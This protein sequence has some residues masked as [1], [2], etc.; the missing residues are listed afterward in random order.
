MLK[1]ENRDSKTTGKNDG[2]GTNED[3]A[4]ACTDAGSDCKGYSHGQTGWCILYGKGMCTVP[5]DMDSNGYTKPGWTGYCQDH[6]DHEITIRK[7]N[8]AYICVVKNKDFGKV[9]TVDTT[10]KPADVEVSSTDRQGIIVVLFS[11]WLTCIFQ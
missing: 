10:A 7:P 6:D 4:Q 11:L 3:C 8:A 1:P 9:D 5:A 2:P